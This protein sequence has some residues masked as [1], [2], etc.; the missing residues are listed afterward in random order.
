M[1]KRNELNVIFKTYNQ[2]QAMLLPP[3]LEELIPAYHPVGVVNKVIDQLDIQPLSNKYKPGGT[4]SF[5][6][7]ML[8]KVLVYAYIN[9]VYSSRKIEEAVQQNFP[10]M[11]LAALN[12]P[13]HNTINPFRGERLKDVLKQIFTQVV[14]LL[15]AE[16]L[17]N[18]KS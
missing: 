11:W 8:L 9:N 18:K 16:G 7:R 13:D 1:K 14:Q 6:P 17:L 4:S 5:H 2:G 15:V 12:M 10:Y 3:S